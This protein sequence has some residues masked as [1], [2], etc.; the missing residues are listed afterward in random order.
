MGQL[1]FASIADGDFCF[2]VPLLGWFIRPYGTE[3]GAQ[4]GTPM[5]DLVNLTPPQPSH[6]DAAIEGIK[7]GLGGV[8]GLLAAIL[9]TPIEKRRDEWMWDVASKLIQ[10]D[11]KVEGFSIQ[12][13]AKNEVFISTLLQAASAAQRTHVVEKRIALRNAVLR[14]ALAPSFDETKAEI[15]VNLIDSITAW[16]IK[17]LDLYA[18]PEE[19]LAR[20][21]KGL[22][23]RIS[24]GSRA[25][26]LELAYPELT[27][28]RTFYDPI[29]RDLYNKGLLRA[30]S[31]HGMV[32][33]RGMLDPLCTEWGC[34]LVLLVRQV[35]ELNEEDRPTD[36]PT[37]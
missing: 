13:L 27:D 24:S 12:S 8:P 1:P 21:G 32:T 17:I 33:S 22:D 4:E 34:E 5:T 16:H 37:G 20:H 2:V 29:V 14:T 10:L 6:V 26:V 7:A 28:Q 36:K 35:P 18:N 3:I 11:N 9:K 31:L 19:W 23:N 15:L 30:E 25:H